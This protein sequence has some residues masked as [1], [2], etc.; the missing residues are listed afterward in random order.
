MPSYACHP[1]LESCCTTH[2]WRLRL[3]RDHRFRRHVLEQHRSSGFDDLGPVKWSLAMCLLF[4]F[5]LVYFSIWKGV[6][7]S[8]KVG[9]VVTTTT[10]LSHIFSWHAVLILVSLLSWPKGC[11]DHSSG[12]VFRVVCPPGAR[13]AAGRIVWRHQ[14]LPV[15]SMG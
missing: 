10:T 15:S 8:G 3:N 9:N 4:V 1:M 14:I 12:T 5:L 7:S 13:S 11:L 6:K 2:S